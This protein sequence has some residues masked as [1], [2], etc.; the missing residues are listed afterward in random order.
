MELKLRLV[1]LLDR[2]SGIYFNLI[3][4]L[5]QPISELPWPKVVRMSWILYHL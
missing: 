2:A 4:Q 1:L 5:L 3:Y